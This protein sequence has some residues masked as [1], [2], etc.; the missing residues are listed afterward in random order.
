MKKD[1]NLRENVLERK[2]V[3][4]IKETVAIHNRLSSLKNLGEA[5]L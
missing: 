1:K 5:S 4:Q 3:S 2:Q